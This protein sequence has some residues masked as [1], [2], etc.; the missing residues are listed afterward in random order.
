[1]PKVSQDLFNIVTV[2]NID[3]EDFTFE[4]DGEPYIVRAGATQNLPRFMARLMVKHLIDKI[5]ER[6]DKKG[7]LMSNAQER[8]KLAAQ[9]VVHEQKYE[10]PAQ[11]TSREIV[12]QMNE[13][14]DIDTVLARNKKRLKESPAR[15]LPEQ[16]EESE[17]AET[18]NPSVA[19][20]ESQPEQ[21][22]SAKEEFGGLTESGEKPMPS[23]EEMMSH[24]KNV[25]KLDITDPKTLKAWEGLSDQQLF[26]ELQMDTI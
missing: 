8:E 22:L 6:R 24:A 18:I 9:I 25:L 26:E 3:I 16:V 12:E 10:K 21:T 14:S 2:K 5:L 13:E 11:P 4:V 23:R 17:P 1:M 15:V 20:E 7:V 19:Q